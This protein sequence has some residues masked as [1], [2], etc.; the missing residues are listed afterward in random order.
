MRTAL[1]ALTG[2]QKAIAALSGVGIAATGM[3]VF[4]S[5][6]ISLPATAAD[7]ESRISSLEES[8]RFQNC[9]LLEMAASRD[10][11]PCRYLLSNP[12]EFRPPFNGG[13]Q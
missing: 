8:R 3:V 11:N 13:P 6:Y 2:A 12:D 10:P 5:G 9:F 7:H 4:L 1:T